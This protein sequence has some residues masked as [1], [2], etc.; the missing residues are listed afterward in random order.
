MFEW[1]VTARFE[2]F[3]RDFRVDDLVIT[4][5]ISGGAEAES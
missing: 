2:W 4:T 3:I 1:F 5:M